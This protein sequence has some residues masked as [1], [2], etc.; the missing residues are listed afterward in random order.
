MPR[1]SSTAAGSAMRV[2]LY[3][4]SIIIMIIIIIIS[5]SRGSSNGTMNTIVTITMIVLSIFELTFIVNDI[6][7]G[8]GRT[9]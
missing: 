4:H 5:S 6:N 8:F 3:S 9:R 2:L 7:L 1:V